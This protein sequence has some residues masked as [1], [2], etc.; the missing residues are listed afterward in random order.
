LTRY[1]LS[2]WVDRFPRSR[3]PSYPQYRGHLDVDAA[4][5]G[6]GLTGSATAYALAAAGVKTVLLEGDRIGRGASGR[7]AGWI[8]DDPGVPFVDVEKALG[9]RSARR[10][11]HAWRRA[12]LDF[13]ALL[14]RL[15]I[16]CDLEPHPMMTVALTPEQVVRFR[17]EQKARRAAGIDAPFVSARAVSGEVAIAAAGGIRTKEGATLDPY[18]AT[19]GL[20]A[21]ASARGARLF[22]QSAVKKIRFNRKTAEITTA[23]GTIR[24]RRLVIATGTP[25]GL[26]H[27]LVRHF[28]F[29]TTYLTL[30]SRLPVKIRQHT[31]KRAVVIRDAAA[32]PHVVRWAGDEQM[33][34]MGA[35][36]ETPPPRQAA[37]TIVQRTGQLMYELST[38]Y[39]EISGI[40]P[41]YGWD[42]AYARTEDGL[43]YIG[44]HRNFPHHLFALGDASH[45][46]TGAYLASRILL[47][48]VLDEVD[49]ADEVFGFARSLVRD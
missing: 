16:K 45:S 42:A 3:V 4:I 31:G 2:P 36:S 43:P 10:A 8:A 23:G 24:T 29:R 22:E 48:H 17:R 7:A 27:A 9:L 46:V 37:K 25:T 11:W 13:T 28:W 38:L 40:V 1:G 32:P 41:E 44:P 39:P 5:V 14:R 15:N 19:L 49:P 34:V 18:R 6:G 26:I 20:A 35:D 21:A 47:R 30:T 12:A 33:L